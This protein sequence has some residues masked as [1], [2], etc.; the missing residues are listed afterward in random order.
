MPD[1]GDPAG[2]DPAADKG[3]PPSWRK[4]GEFV[5]G[6]FDLQR[7]IDRL[8]KQNDRLQNEVTQ[9]Q[10]LVD[11]HSGQLKTVMLLIESTV[12]DRAERHAEAAALKMV[13]QL[14]AFREN[15]PE[16]ED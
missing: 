10:R 13:Q 6:V 4:I 9:L 15:A 7:S 2:R 16:R 5:A 12:N 3:Q 8:Q 11:E 1:A 14:L